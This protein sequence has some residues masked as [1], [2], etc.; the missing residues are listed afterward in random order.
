[1]GHFYPASLSSAMTSAGWYIVSLMVPGD[2]F[3]LTIPM[4]LWMW[5]QCQKKCPVQCSNRLQLVQMSSWLVI[6]G[7]IAF[8]QLF[9]VCRQCCFPAGIVWSSGNLR[10]SL[11]FSFVRSTDFDLSWSLEVTVLSRKPCAV[12][13]LPLETVLGV[14]TSE[15]HFWLSIWIFGT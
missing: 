13:L 4:V 9:V 3:Y 8:N 10:T 2:T 6:Q 5:H 12:P 1:M 15:H 11:Y 7:K 14:E